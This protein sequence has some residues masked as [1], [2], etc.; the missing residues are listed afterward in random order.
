MY[1]YYFYL[2]LFFI[3]KSSANAYRSPVYNKSEPLPPRV[4][5]RLPGESDESDESDEEIK[6]KTKTKTKKD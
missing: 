2:P 1:Y 3:Q 4:I 5:P 6:I